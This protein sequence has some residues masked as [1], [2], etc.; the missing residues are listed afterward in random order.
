MSYQNKAFIPP[1]FSNFGKLNKDLFKKKFDHE[2]VFK[3]INKTKQGMTIEAGSNLS[4]GYNGFLKGKWSVANYEMEKEIYTS[5][6]SENKCSVKVKNVAPGL[7]FT[8]GGSSQD[9]QLNN[10]VSGSLDLEYSRDHFTTNIIGRT[11]F[12]DTKVD[13]SAVV[14]VD[15]VSLGGQLV[16][17]VAKGA[18]V[19]DINVGAEYSKDD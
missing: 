14:G 19:A 4:Q 17:N 13:A 12:A 9:K 11:N 18:E 16:V 6:K 1:K 15:P 10:S 5:P 7:I 2:H 3:T 8:L